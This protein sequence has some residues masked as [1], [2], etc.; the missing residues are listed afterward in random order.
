MP[1]LIKMLEQQIRLVLQSPDKVKQSVLV[2][3]KTFRRYKKSLAY[4]RIVEDDEFDRAHGTETS[5]RVHVTDLKIQNIN[6]IH[7]EPY[8]PTP[9]RLLA[10]IVE[11]LDLQFENLTF[12]DLGSGKGRVLL[13]ASQFPF[14][15]IVGVELSKELDAIARKNIAAYRGEQRCKSIETICGDFT[16]F[17][18]PSEPLFVYLYNPTSVQLSQILARNLMHSVKQCPRQVWILY[19]APRIMFYAEDALEQVKAGEHAYG[20][21]PYCLYR[22]RGSYLR[23]N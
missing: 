21:H 10:D 5:R 8:F 17:E 14:R 1:K 22:T 7:A 12:V 16:T 6:W 3:F 18:F 13:M 15:R 4:T 19:V 11:G 9:S 23:A 2:P 20:N